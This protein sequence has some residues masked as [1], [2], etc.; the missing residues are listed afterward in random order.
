MKGASLRLKGTIYK[1]CVQ[2]VLVYNRDM[3]NKGESHE[4]IEKGREYYVFD[5]CMV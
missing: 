4:E 3:G 2:R 5:G 1:L